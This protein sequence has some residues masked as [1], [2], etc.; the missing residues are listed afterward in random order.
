MSKKKKL[1]FWLVIVFAITLVVL[2]VIV[3]MVS[4][5]RNEYLPVHKDRL[6]TVYERVI[7]QTEPVP[8]F[9]VAPE[10]TPE[11]IP[12]PELSPSPVITPGKGIAL[13]MDD[14]GYDLHALRRILD[15]SVPVAIAVLPGAPFARESASLSHQ[16]GQTVMLHLPM[17]P[18]VPKY[19]QRMTDTFLRVDMSESELRQTFLQDLEKIPHVEGVNNHM[20]SRLTQLERP[21][22]W[23]M[24]ICQE[25]GLFFV[26]SKTSGTSVGQ[27]ISLPVWASHGRRAATFSIINLMSSPC[28]RPGTM[29]G[30]VRKKRITVS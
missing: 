28:S 3:G 13:V 7:P 30:H 15:L 2:L 9:E 27:Q 23:V 14:V 26:D 17:E 1:P 21:M 24:R 5:D 16:H 4:S 11:P 29:Q 6:E 19:Q 10:A 20:G 8:K 18:L 25:K 22:S 12:E